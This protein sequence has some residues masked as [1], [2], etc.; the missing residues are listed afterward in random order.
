[1]KINKKMVIMFLMLLAVM[2]IIF[3]FSSHT[4]NESSN[5]SIKVTRFIS[6]IIFRNFNNMS[7]SQQQFIVNELH[8]FVRKLAHFTI[9][10]IL[11]IFM[12]F[13][14]ALTEIRFKFPTAWILCIIYAATDEYHQSFTPGRTMQLKDVIIDSSGAF[15]GILAAIVI[16][17]VFEYIRKCLT[18]KSG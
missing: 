3:N 4:G 5:L 18:G 7:L 9:Y 16:I 1:M 8:L 10:M 6:R 12:Y 15:C 2:T 14:I 17:A 13:F 11:G